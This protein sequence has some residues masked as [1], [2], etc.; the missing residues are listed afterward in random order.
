MAER[1][2]IVSE[3][4]S[5]SPPDKPE[6]RWEAIK[7]RLSIT[8]LGA[9]ATALAAIV[10]LIVLF[11]PSLLPWT[12]FRTSITETDVEHNASL[13]RFTDRVY[14]QQFVKQ[15]KGLDENDEI[16][17]DYE[18]LY[19]PEKVGDVRGNV[20]SYRVEAEGYQSRALDVVWS[21]YKD[22]GTR[23]FDADAVYNGHYLVDVP[24]WPV[25]SVVSERRNDS[26][27]GDVFVPIPPR[28]KD[29]TYYVKIDAWDRKDQTWGCSLLSWWDP[30]K[31]DPVRMASAITKKFD[32]EGGESKLSKNQ[33]KS[34]SVRGA[35]PSTN[36]EGTQKAGA[37]TNSKSIQE[38][39]PSAKSGGAA[40]TS[41]QELPKTGGNSVSLSSW[42]TG[43][44]LVVGGLLTRRGIS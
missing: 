4:E 33:E 42:G 41:L 20:V 28:L 11:F 40:G 19:D 26:I 18:T 37:L 21:L 6:T 31:C 15:V 10:G 27:H 8:N 2:S 30:G 35:G 7:R 5:T 25:G 1:V 36:P 14:A 23:D 3:Q 16:R 44:P 12:S 29:G 34:E 39:E 22:P 24:G 13:E 38:T 32:I 17:K 9:L 43:V